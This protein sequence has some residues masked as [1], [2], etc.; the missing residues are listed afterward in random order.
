[1]KKTK[2]LIGFPEFYENIKPEMDA[3][4]I[5][6][7]RIRTNKTQFKGIVKAAYLKCFDFNY[8]ISISKE[9]EIIFF[10]LETLRS[11]CEDLI[12]IK[13]LLN[14]PTKER[15]SYVKF[16]TQFNLHKSLIT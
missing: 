5:F 3:L 11:L 15:N 14:L 1:M 4:R 8:Y 13:Y 12:S 9:K 7:T 16:S 6:Y 2:K 10:Q